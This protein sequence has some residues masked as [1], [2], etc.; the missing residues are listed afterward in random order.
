MNIIVLRSGRY[1]TFA[2]LLSFLALSFSAAENQNNYIIVSC[3]TSENLCLNYLGLSFIIEEDDTVLL[4]GSTL[5]EATGFQSS[6]KLD[7]EYSGNSTQTSFSSAK[8][9]A[10]VAFFT[11]NGSRHYF[12]GTYY[13]SMYV[14]PTLSD[15]KSEYSIDLTDEVN[16]V[17][18]LIYPGGSLED[19]GVRGRISFEATIGNSVGRVG[20]KRYITIPLHAIGNLYVILPDVTIPQKA[21][22]ID[23]KINDRDMRRMTPYRFDA[24]ASITPLEQSDLRIY[25]AWEMPSEVPLFM[26]YPY[27]YILNT[28]ISVIIGFGVKYLYDLTKSN[29]EKKSLVRKLIMELRMNNN[30]LAKHKPVTTTIY[31]VSI[32]KFPLLD[33]KTVETLI[34]TYQNIRATNVRGPSVM[35]H[36]EIEKLRSEIQNAISELQKHL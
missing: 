1:L 18:E 11:S 35:T 21:D 25:L 33:D 28:I 12:V 8:L 20:N 31:D 7:I 29:R 22:L 13:K 36:Q 26:T 24:S 23:A 16:R 15:H 14:D 30:S 17:R 10:D 34:R 9:I 4:I 5:F 27:N 2:L 32:A 3:Y 19:C 6:F